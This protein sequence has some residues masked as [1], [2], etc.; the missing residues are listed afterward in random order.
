MILNPFN[1]FDWKPKIQLL[2]CSKGR[3]RITMGNN[4]EPKSSIY[5]LNY[6]NKNWILFFSITHNLLFHVRDC[7]TPHDVQTKL[8][9]LFGK[10][11]ELRGHHLENELFI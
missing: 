1:Y 9:G 7:K 11:D 6:F 5:K 10:K 2:L 3:F 8:D 4:I